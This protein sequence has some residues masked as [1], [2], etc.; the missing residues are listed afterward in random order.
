MRAGLA[1]LD[2]EPRAGR[3][4]AA[5]VGA[6]VRDA[7]GAPGASRFNDGQLRCQVA[8][9]QDGREIMLLD[10]CTSSAL[11]DPVGRA[12][13]LPFDPADPSRALVSRGVMGFVVVGGVVF[14]GFGALARRSGSCSCADG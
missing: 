7:A 6:C 8:F 4:L 14:C 5:L 13:E 11:S 9:V 2:P 12:V 10:Q 1:G 3:P